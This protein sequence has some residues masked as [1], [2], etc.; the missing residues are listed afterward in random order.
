MSD[1]IIKLKSPQ[2][3]LQAN[4]TVSNNMTTI[5]SGSC[6]RLFNS[7]AS[8]NLLVTVYAANAGVIAMDGT[9]SGANLNQLTAYANVT[10][11]FNQ[12]LFLYKSP[13]DS[14]TGNANILASSIAFQ[15]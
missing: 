15:G 9:V 12:E 4:N 14:L 6:V 8:V 11:G 13:T 7:H 1:R 2:I 5:A 3:A 10:I